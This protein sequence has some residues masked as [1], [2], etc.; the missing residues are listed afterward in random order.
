MTFLKESLE[1]KDEI[2]EEEDED[3]LSHSMSIIAH[4]EKVNKSTQHS[5]IIHSFFPCFII[6]TYNV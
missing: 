4:T 6:F 2:K 1:D 3:K 5:I